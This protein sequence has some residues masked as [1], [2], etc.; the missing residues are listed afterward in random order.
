MYQYGGID[1]F[2]SYKAEE[3]LHNFGEEELTGGNDHYHKFQ[4]S[5]NERAIAHAP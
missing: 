5:D 2:Q 4:R 3:R 1:V